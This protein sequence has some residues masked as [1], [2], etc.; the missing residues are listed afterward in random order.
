MSA[1]KLQG[2][3]MDEARAQ[4]ALIQTVST[5]LI[6]HENGGVKPDLWARLREAYDAYR[7]CHGAVIDCMCEA[8]EQVQT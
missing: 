4:G 8:I 5:M 3:R 1:D 7:A 2:L 6:Y